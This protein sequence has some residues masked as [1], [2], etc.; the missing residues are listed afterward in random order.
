[1]KEFARIDWRLPPQEEVLLEDL[2]MTI[3]SRR[4]F[5]EAQ[6][7]DSLHPRYDSLGDPFGLQDMEL[8]VSAILDFRDKNEKII[9]YGDYDIDGLTASSLL[10]DVCSQLHIKHEVYIPDR[11]EEGYGIHVRALEKL[12]EQGARTIVSVDC[13]SSALE[14]AQAAQR[15]GIRLII[16]DHHALIAQELEGA[17]AHINPLREANQY[18]EKYLSGVGVAF[19]LARAL[20]QA[21]EYSIPAGQEKW[22]LDL[23]ALGTICD[24]V[25]LTGEN[26]VLASYGLQ[27]LRKTRRAGLRA[28]A[29]VSG[30]MLEGISAEDLGFKLGP[31]LN[32]AGRLEHAQHALKMLLAVDYEQAFEHAEYLQ[33]LNTQRQADTKWIHES[34]REQAQRYLDDPILVLSDTS[35]SHGIVGLVASR[36]SEEYHR[37]AFLLQLEGNLAK[38]SGRS[39]AGISI[40]DIMRKQ[41]AILDR[42]GGHAAA[43][44]MTIASEKIDLF[45]ERMIETVSQ[46]GDDVWTKQ[47][48][49]DAWLQPEFVSLE[50]FA[51]LEKLE[52]TGRDHPGVRFVFDG[53]ITGIRPVGAD[54]SHYQ[55]SVRVQEREQRMIA[56]GAAV[57]WP[58]LKMGDIIRGVVRLGRSEWRGVARIEVMLLDI[59]DNPYA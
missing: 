54:G 32:A 46:L 9:I 51:Q 6:S 35:W 42:Y 13:G 20:Q 36:I 16:T 7:L 2:A 48:T 21:S 53:E 1:M 45:R 11:F 29:R 47:E 28:L 19:A 41:D 24:V 17:Y 57:K 33:K 26:R 43:A 50:G 14:A 18:P 49:V 44:G 23:V 15:L 58:L 37:P 52:P 8:A 25:P 40:I 22:L 56:F 4:G 3:L 12:S 38:G 39:Y 31:R 59:L 10:A 55:L 34:A 27:V 5:S 30:V